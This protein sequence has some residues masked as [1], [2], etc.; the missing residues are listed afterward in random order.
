MG[1]VRVVVVLSVGVSS[2]VVR[3]VLLLTAA[4]GPL[5]VCVIPVLLAETDEDNTGVTGGVLVACGLVGFPV[6]EG[7]LVV[8]VDV[9]CCV[10]TTP[11]SVL[12]RMEEEA[13]RSLW[14]SAVLEIGR[15]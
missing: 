8:L 15:V 1:Y 14:V 12:R 9:V 13:L 6:L 5:P 4:D 11:A 10:L 7:L 2:T 3:S